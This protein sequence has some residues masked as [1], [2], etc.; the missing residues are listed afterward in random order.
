MRTPELTQCFVWF[1]SAVHMHTQL[2]D[3]ANEL[4]YG[5]KCFRLMSDSA[6]QGIQVKNKNKIQNNAGIMHSNRGNA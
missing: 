5:L 3:I 6:S 1:F 2:C 4:I